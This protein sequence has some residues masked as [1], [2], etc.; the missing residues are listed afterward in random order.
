M[1][2][3]HRV[4]LAIKTLVRVDI[5]KPLWPL[6]KKNDIVITMG[7]G[8]ISKTG[9]EILNLLEEKGLPS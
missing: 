4:A 5:P 6:L 1:L 7:A 2:V 9:P 8:D 3:N